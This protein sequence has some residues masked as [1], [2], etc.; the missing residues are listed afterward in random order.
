MLL[1]DNQQEIAIMAIVAGD[2]WCVLS[3]NLG[4]APQGMDKIK[5]CIRT[6]KDGFAVSGVE[7]VDGKESACN[8]LA[9]TR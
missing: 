9:V 6:T 7:I 1:G 5:Y 8:W 3:T 2:G 4:P